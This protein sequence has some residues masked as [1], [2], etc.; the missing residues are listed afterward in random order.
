[1]NKVPNR[2]QYPR[3]TAL[4]SVKYTVREGTFRDLTGNIGAGG[5]FVRTR[6]NRKQ[7]QR[8]N[9]QFPILA[10]KKPLSIM[11]TVVRC[12]SEGFAVMF[13][14]PIEAKIYKKGQFPK[15]AQEGNRST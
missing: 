11:G 12:S 1:M 6:W 9:L 8:I 15:I 2:R 14:E 3:Q 13:D 5:V 10:F 4:F 7:G